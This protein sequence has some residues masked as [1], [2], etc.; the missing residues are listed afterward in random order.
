MKYTEQ[1]TE[2]VAEFALAIFC[3][4]MDRRLEPGYDE[5]IAMVEAWRMAAE[6]LKSNPLADPDPKV[7]ISISE[8]IDA[9]LSAHCILTPADVVVIRKAITAPPSDYE[10]RCDLC[11]A[12]RAALALLPVPAGEGKTR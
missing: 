8:K 2:R 11:A 10:C 7:P 1:K 3:K 12:S 9:L 6:L 5:S 4:L